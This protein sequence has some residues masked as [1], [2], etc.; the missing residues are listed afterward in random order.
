MAR[1]VQQGQLLQPLERRVQATERWFLL[2]EG[3]RDLVA[4]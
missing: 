1:S 2:E 3:G 4:Q